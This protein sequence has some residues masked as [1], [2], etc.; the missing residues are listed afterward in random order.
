MLSRSSF[1]GFR[2]FENIET[3]SNKIRSDWGYVIGECPLMMAN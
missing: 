2:G 1:K 3:Y